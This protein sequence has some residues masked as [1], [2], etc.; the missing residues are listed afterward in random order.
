MQSS[1]IPE[2]KQKKTQKLLVYQTIYQENLCDPSFN[3]H[4][5]SKNIFKN[6]NQKQRK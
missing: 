4:I 5:S 1:Y 3:I 2:T 6:F